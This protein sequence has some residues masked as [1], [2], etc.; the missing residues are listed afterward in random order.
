MSPPGVGPAHPGAAP[1]RCPARG[2]ENTLGCPAWTREAAAGAVVSASGRCAKD[3]S[4]DQRRKATYPPPVFGRF[5]IVPQPFDLSDGSAMC[6]RQPLR[7]IRVALSTFHVGL[8]SFIVRLRRRRRVFSDAVERPDQPSRDDACPDTSRSASDGESHARADRGAV[9]RRVVTGRLTVAG[10]NGNA[11][12]ENYADAGTGR[13]ANGRSEPLADRPSKRHADTAAV[14]HSDTGFLV[15][16]LDRYEPVN[17]GH[18][19]RRDVRAGSRRLDLHRKLSG[20]V[21][22]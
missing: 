22:P 5:G 8:T 2:R 6:W 17:G 9:A 20:H 7:R 1:I 21:S 16:D 19:H 3:I 4:L 11:D 14:V 13:L 12:P 10:R 15:A 18:F